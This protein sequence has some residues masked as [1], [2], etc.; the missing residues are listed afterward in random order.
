MWFCELLII[1]HFTDTQKIYYYPGALAWRLAL[2]H[3]LKYCVYCSTLTPIHI[4]TWQCLLACALCFRDYLEISLAT[5]IA[6]E[7]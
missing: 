7:L 6:P 1:C 5:L 2:K 3:T 4:M